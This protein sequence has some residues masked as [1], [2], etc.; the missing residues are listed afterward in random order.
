MAEAQWDVNSCF[1]VLQSGRILE[2][3]N[4]DHLMQNPNGAYAQ[5]IRTREQEKPPETAEDADALPRQPRKS[6]AARKSIAAGARKS[7]ACARKS[8]A[9]G[10][11]QG[12]SGRKSVYPQA[13]NARMSVF[14]SGVDEEMG[15]VG[16]SSGAAQRGMRSSV[17]GVQ[18]A[19]QAF[20]RMR[21]SVFGSY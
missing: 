12:S 7:I 11:P 3:G 15:G 20:S 18:V 10:A 8:V 6:M 13:G 17:G 1:V 2:Q 19:G 16:P 5:L 4:H 21:A 9:G 14:G